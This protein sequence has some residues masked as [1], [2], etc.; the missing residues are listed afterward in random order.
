MHEETA[1]FVLYQKWSPR[2]QRDK[3]G[4]MFEAKPTKMITVFPATMEGLNEAIAT[5]IRPDAILIKLP[6]D[7]DTSTPLIKYL[8]KRIKEKKFV[9]LFR[10]ITKVPGD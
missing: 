2:A 10:P 9:K 8:E 5:A 6:H 1:K 3:Y 4:M 7:Y